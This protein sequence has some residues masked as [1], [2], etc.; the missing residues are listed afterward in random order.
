MVFIAL[1]LLLS[2]ALA[3]DPGYAL[4]FDG[5]NDY[6]YLGDTGTVLGNGN[7]TSTKSITL[8]VFVTGGSPPDTT[9]PSGEML[10]GTDRPRLFGLQR[11]MFNGQDAIWGWNSDGIGFNAVG[12]SYA[13]GE[14]FH[15]ALVHNNDVLSLYKNGILVGSVASGDTYL[16]SGVI[17]GNLYLGG[18]GRSA[19]P[20]YFEG[21][22][23]EVGFW[24]IALTQSDIS[25]L[26][27]SVYTE[28]HPLW[29][30]L[31]A[32]YR[33][34]DG[35]G[36]VLSDDSNFDNTG[37]LLGG[38]SSANWVISGAFGGS[39]DPTPTGTETQL[40]T[41]TPT[42][43]LTP[44]S[45]ATAT[46]TPTINQSA[47][48]SPTAT[49][50]QPVT[51]TPTSTAT[52]QPA[53]TST[54][55]ST[56]LP[57]HTP[58]HTSTPT[59]TATAIPTPTPT[60]PN[61]AT[62]SPTATLTQTPTLTATSLL[63]QTSTPTSTGEPQ[64]SS[65][66]TNTATP[67]S[68]GT[69]L[70]EI[71]F[72]DST[73]S[74]YDIKV[75]GDL[76]YLA[77]V[78]GGLQ[79]YDVSNP[80]QPVLRGTLPFPVRAYGVDVQGPYAY[81]ADIRAGLRIVD[82]SS[83]ASPVQVGAHS[84]PGMAFD[85]TVS[86]DYAY[87][88][89]RFG[90]L[91]IFNVANPTSP[92]EVGFIIPGSETLSVAVVDSYAF[93]ANYY[94]GMVVVDVQNPSLPTISA[95][96]DTSDAYGIQISGAYAYVADGGNGLHIFDIT[97]PSAP[98]RVGGFDTPG[99]S[100]SLRVVGTLVYIADW[101]TGLSVVDASNIVLPTGI[102]QYQGGI[103]RIR[104]VDVANGYIFLADYDYGLRILTWQ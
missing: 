19:S 20:L 6:V 5:N 24:N 42:Q 98:I 9:P 21:Q 103:G 22:F 12:T 13:L 3:D 69:A 58:T 8:W 63:T 45:T 78:M 64:P 66:P 102:T 39:G 2:S 29:G 88:A 56:S 31:T 97:N 85:V 57:T 62:S 32:Y 35:E 60:H 96:Y 48:S 40:P 84:T 77:S 90:G 71:G 15:L 67:G 27:N 89:D 43:T 68:P 37:S 74:P 1:S 95:I 23:D 73:G 65:T 17:D 10:V 7:W 33:M 101:S 94:T 28:I 50:S 104:D 34:S 25:S 46:L 59:S 86:G 100:R 83:P 52:N 18:S 72:Y 41:Q 92:V 38:M 54:L 99:W 93:L 55:T 79:I 11:A 4:L 53:L 47:T 61:T 26:M 49:G 75:V 44:T 91:R 87:L 14:W 70:V 76:V 82:V 81:I 16:P 80:S 36:T 51:N 30:D